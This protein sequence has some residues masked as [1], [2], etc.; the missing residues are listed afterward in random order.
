MRSTG[1][2]RKIDNLGRIT[3]PKELR[4]SFNIDINDP[5]EIF[6][7]H[8]MIIL[9]KLETEDIFTG[10]TENLIEFKGKKVSEETIIELAKIAGFEITNKKMQ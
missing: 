1:I 4:D 8:S 9:K 10:S 2:I 7:S 6:A 3:L 5:I